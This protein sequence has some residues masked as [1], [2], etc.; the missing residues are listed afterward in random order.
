[1]TNTTG[2]TAA[3]NPAAA[4]IKYALDNS[5]ESPIEF[6]RCWFD[7]DFQAIRDEWPDA[8]E[9]VF[10]G[11]DPQHP[12]TKRLA[13]DRRHAGP[14]KNFELREIANLLEEASRLIAAIPTSH[15]MRGSPYPKICREL[16]LGATKIREIAKDYPV[17]TP[18][19]HEAPENE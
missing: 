1:M 11:A 3:P 14:N 17:M 13:D 7:G 12:F 18:Y 8:P 2:D 19:Y 6:L 10:V 4:A 15:I 16:N 9:E 5:T